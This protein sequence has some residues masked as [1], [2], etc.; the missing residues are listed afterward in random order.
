MKIILYCQY[1]WGIGHFFRSLEICRA[2]SAH[3][4]I[5]VSGGLPVDISLPEHV[6]EVRLPGLMVDDDY[7]TLVP[8]IEENSVDQIK[9]QRRVRL[10]KLFKEES[11]DLF[12]VELYPFGRRAFR[13]E[14]DPIFKEIR[15][16]HLPPCSVVC[17]LR[18]ILVEKK[19]PVS[20]EK[21]VTGALNRYFDALLI[22]SD[23]GFV[24]LDET[25]SSIGEIDIPLVYTGFVA[26]RPAPDAR[27]RLRSRLGLRKKERL[28]VASAGGGRSGGSL[29]EAVVEALSRMNSGEPTYLHIFTGPFVS[30]AVFDRLKA[31]SSKTVCVSHFAHDFL[32]YLAAADLSVSMAGYNT[33]MNIL[34]TGVPSVVWPFPEDREQ[35]IRAEKMAR[36]GATE[37]LRQ[38]DLHPQHLAA[39]VHRALSRGSRFTV[40]VDLNGAKNT[41][42]WIESFQKSESG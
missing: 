38:K 6:R 14:L 11:P 29:L 19:D 25:F 12:L 18:D 39:I 26:Q 10:Q 9:R 13:Y 20:Y 33:C 41:A 35:G 40:Q 7:K 2:L 32:S 30:N 8:A 4:M 27:V 34:A 36:I 22:H 21:R 16:G 1:V 23:P 28:I 37:V 15:N 5:L 31:H 17:S 24:K 42:N 3:K